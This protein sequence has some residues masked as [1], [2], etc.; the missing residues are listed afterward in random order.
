MKLDRNVTLKNLKKK[1][2]VEDRGKHHVYYCFHHNNKKTHIKTRA[3]H[4]T[5][6]KD[7]KD[8]IIKSMAEQ[9]HLK[10]DQFRDLAICDMSEDEYARILI[11]SG[12]IKG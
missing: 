3:S 5:K 8:D 9:C 1:G 7:L 4:G 11:E 6:H 2:F 12:E 10:K